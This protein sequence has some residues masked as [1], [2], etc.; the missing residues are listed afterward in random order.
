MIR[1]PPRST[2]FPYTTL[3]R[4]IAHEGGHAL[5]GWLLGRSIKSI[6]LARD[7]GGLTVSTGAGAIGLFVTAVAGY[8]GPSVFGF[9]GAMMLVHDF[10]P[11]AV[12]LLSLAFLAL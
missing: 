7:M 4:T 12:L 6:T 11:R 9:A 10:Q 2:L 1:R 5:F 3:F 8:L